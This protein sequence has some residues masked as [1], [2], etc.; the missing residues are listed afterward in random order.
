[1]NNRGN[2]KFIVDNGLVILYN[3]CLSSIIDYEDRFLKISGE[4]RNNRKKLKIRN[5]HV[6]QL[7]TEIIN[8][9]ILSNVQ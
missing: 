7:K 3:S 9:D 4:F 8:D 1:M 2:L 6:R 5:E